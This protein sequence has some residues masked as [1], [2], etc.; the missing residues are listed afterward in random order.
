MKKNA[1]SNY[2]RFMEMTDAQRD[3]EV[4]QFDQEFIADTFGPPMPAQCRQWQRLKKKMGRP[5][6]GKGVKV[7]SLSIEQGLLARADAMAKR[8]GIS[9]ARLVA[10]GLERMHAEAS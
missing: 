3:A 10:R 5:Q 2:Q 4:R 1:K 9:R 8:Q 7:I 6:M